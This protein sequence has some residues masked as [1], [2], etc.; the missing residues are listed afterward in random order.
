M[1]DSKQDTLKQNRLG[2]LQGKRKMGWGILAV[3]ATSLVWMGWLID[4][5]G[6]DWTTNTAATDPSAKSVDMRP[7]VIDLPPEQLAAVVRRWV[8]S[9]ARWSI[10]GSEAIAGGERLHLLHQTRLLRF[11]DDVHVTLIAEEA[12]G[13][14]TTLSAHSQSR[15]G[16][17][18]LGQNPR[19]IK[20]LIAGVRAET[21][22]TR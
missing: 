1:N 5:W 21:E 10:A 4:D 2:P 14:P 6:R 18:D 17:G 11:T 15:I 9:E 16:K 13:R 20:Q 8:D 12:T 7:L 19:N 22:R 3:V